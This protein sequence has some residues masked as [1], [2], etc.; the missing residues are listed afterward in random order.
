M[1]KGI[2][3]S[4]MGFCVGWLLGCSLFFVYLLLFSVC[5]AQLLGGGLRLCVFGVCIVRVV[6]FGCDLRGGASLLVLF[7]ALVDC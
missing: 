4:S 6:A 5:S 3:I 2:F 7:S 1:E